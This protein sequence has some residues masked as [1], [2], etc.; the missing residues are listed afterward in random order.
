MLLKQSFCQPVVIEGPI[1]CHRVT[2]NQQSA[3][4][5]LLAVE[6][7]LIN[8]PPTVAVYRFHGSIDLILFEE[9]ATDRLLLD[10]LQPES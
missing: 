4:W 5:Q 1:V 8:H 2:R 7:L 10:W 9:S 6:H 3:A